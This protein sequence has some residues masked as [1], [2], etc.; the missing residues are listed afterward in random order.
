MADSKT[1]VLSNVPF[2]R[3]KHQLEKT[4]R[5]SSSGESAPKE[6]LKTTNG[7]MKLESPK[8]KSS[9][10]KQVVS[11]K[12]GSVSPQK[13]PEPEKESSQTLKADEKVSQKETSANKP[14]VITQV[15]AK[16]TGNDSIQSSS[17]VEAK[18][19]PAA[20][21]ISTPADYILGFDV[22]PKKNRAKSVLKKNSKVPVASPSTATL[23][24]SQLGLFQ[25]T[26]KKET[27]FG[28][29]IGANGQPSTPTALT[30]TDLIA[31]GVPTSVN[32]VSTLSAAKLAEIQSS[33]LNSQDKLSTPSVSE[34]GSGLTDRKTTASV[35]STATVA[36]ISSTVT[37][38]SHVGQALSSVTSA[39]ARRAS[40]GTN[41]TNYQEIFH[42][43]TRRISE[44]AERGLKQALAG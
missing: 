18:S 1:I 25:P 35:A 2:P 15:S 11:D 4:Q 37:A 27:P 12:P 7:T 30:A 20:Q 31:S 3:P 34:I 39:V 16:S 42:T 26:K 29:Q 36:S 33:L 44:S 41:G 19:S 10:N 8:D 28:S 9:P 38:N 43:A 23:I 17:A 32:S 13:K 40:T 6:A 21:T 24:T 14:S 22:A 5:L